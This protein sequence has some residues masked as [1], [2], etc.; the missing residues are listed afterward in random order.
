MP[1]DLLTRQIHISYGKSSFIAVHIFIIFVIFFHKFYE[2]I[3]HSKL[4]QIQVYADCFIFFFRQIL[5]EFVNSFFTI[6]NCID[7]HHYNIQLCHWQVPL[8]DFYFLLFTFEFRYLGNYLVVNIVGINKSFESKITKSWEAGGD[9]LLGQLGSNGILR[10]CLLSYDLWWLI[11][12]YWYSW[13]GV[14]SL[15][16][17][18]IWWL[19]CPYIFF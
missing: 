3:A 9:L 10:G 13:Q 19:V 18:I 14:F 17:W 16:R 8:L 6:K 12:G 15:E 5:R 7:R 1:Q 2:C 11:L 4:N